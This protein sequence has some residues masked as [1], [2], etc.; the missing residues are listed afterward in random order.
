MRK[1]PTKNTYTLLLWRVTGSLLL[2]LLLTI[3]I[4]C[5]GASVGAPSNTQQSGTLSLGSSGLNFGSVAAGSNKTLTLTATN[6]GSAPITI[7][8]A[9][10]STQYFFLSGPLLPVTVAPSQSATLTI[11]FTPNTAGTFNATAII[12]STASDNTTHVSLSGAGTES[13]AG[14]L[15]LNPASANFGSVTVGSSQPLPETV[16]NTGG[17]S[18]TISQAAISGSE[19]TMSGIST[20]L[21]IQPGQSVPFTVTFTPESTGAA[22]ATLTFTSDATPST[23][24]EQLSG[25]GTSASTHAVNLSWDASTSPN[26]SGYNIYRAVYSGACG[27]FAKINSLLNTSTVFTDSEVVNGTSYCYAT[28]AVNASEEESSYSNIVSNI[29]IPAS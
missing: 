13:A 2:L 6:T 23:T 22:S 10:I 29:Q 12:T 19:F 20:P 4:G 28:T 5:Q 14:Q 15:T 9:S 8:S 18:V 3:L 11:E 24:S 26:I 27:S 25:T 7:S 17:A 21:T 16:T 1:R